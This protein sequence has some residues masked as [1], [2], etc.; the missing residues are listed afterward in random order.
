[1][2]ISISP[3]I[4]TVITGILI[5]L[6]SEQEENMKAIIN[7]KSICHPR[8]SISA[9]IMLLIV[10][11]TAGCMKEEKEPAK[12]MEQLR[13]ENGV[14]V[15]VKAIGTTSFSKSLHYYAT[16]KGIKESIKGSSV[17]DK[18][19]KINAKAGD[20]VKQGQIV[21]EFPNDI[22]K[23]G[24][25]QM[26]IGLKTIEKTYNRMQHLLKAG[27]ISQ[28]QFEEVET[29][30]LINKENFAAL[31]RSLYVESPI[32]GTITDIFVSEGDIIVSDMPGKPIPLFKVAQLNKMIAKVWITTDEIAGVRKG[33][34]ASTEVNGTTISGRI[35]GIALS[36]NK[37]H[38][39]FSV[40]ITF[41]NPK[42]LLQSGTTIDI[43]LR[44]YNNPNAI[45]IPRNLI[46]RHSGRDYVFTA[47]NGK[48]RKRYVTLGEGNGMEIEIADGLK[49]NDML[50]TEGASMVG[51]GTKIKIVE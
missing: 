10:I 34:T 6:K 25:R 30:Y 35:T 1:M 29:Q 22:P 49:E 31:N 20:E 28:Q 8:R 36:L 5:N 37:R 21:I 32:D 16:L 15:K 27:D 40:E 46:K 11:L 2:I 45:I 14:P 23:L 19:L 13:I 41:D 4:I 44:T 3:V 7:M 50:I 47:D 9:I 12:S 24:Y 42:R 18:V 33:T 17:G 39:A 51:D 26:E 48:A 43:K 38:Q